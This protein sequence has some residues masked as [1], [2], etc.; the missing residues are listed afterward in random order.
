MP[1]SL[2]D[3]GTLRCAFRTDGNGGFLFVN[4]HIRLHEI[5]AHP[6]HRFV[7]DLENASV[8]FELDIP[9][10][11][12]FFLPVNLTLGG[13]SVRY[14]SAQPVSYAEN[15]L[16]LMRIP[17][18][19][20]V[21][22]LNDGRTVSLT[23]GINR[24]DDTDVVLLQYEEYVPSELTEISAE[25]VPNRCDSALLL[26]QTTVVSAASSSLL[27]FHVGTPPPQEST[28]SA[29]FVRITSASVSSSSFRNASSPCSSKMS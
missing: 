13:L 16:T 10:D 14:A 28:V 17:G 1:S 4:N 27:G 3:T 18:M 7:F 19:E 29:P 21:I 24:I 25:P 8:E 26:S 12:T 20:P 23:E 15:E 22:V 5:P 2:N 6:A 9:A 11:S